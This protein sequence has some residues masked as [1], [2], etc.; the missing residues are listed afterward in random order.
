MRSIEEWKGRTDDTPVPPRV[1]DRI[2]LRHGGMCH[3]SGRKIRAGERWE[4]E[5]VIALCNGG[6]HIE[7]NLAPALVGP[8]REKTANDR[9]IKARDDRIRKRHLGI[10]GK[11]KFAT[12]RDG[13]F[14]RKIDGTVVRR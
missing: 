2:F 3:L 14:K 7:S 12:N 8:H 11:S 6:K 10:R 13:P 9:K 4:V 5:H 1:R